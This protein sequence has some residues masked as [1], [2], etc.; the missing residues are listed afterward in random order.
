M[1]CKPK[2]AIEMERKKG[3]KNTRIKVN[4]PVIT[5][6]HKWLTHRP[7]LFSILEKKK[8]KAEKSLSW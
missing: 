5:T 4:E 6:I 1:K 3:E 8:K 2:F 7:W